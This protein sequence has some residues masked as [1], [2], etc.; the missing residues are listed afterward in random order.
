[1]VYVKLKS[2]MMKVGGSQVAQS[3]WSTEIVKKWPSFF[4]KLSFELPFKAD[5]F[6][7][8]NS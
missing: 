5:F 8:V 2:A 6:F 7:S 4:G 3:F 1:M